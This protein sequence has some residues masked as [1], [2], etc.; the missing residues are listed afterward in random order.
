MQKYAKGGKV[1]KFRRGGTPAPGSK[2]VLGKIPGSRDYLQISNPLSRM[3][4]GPQVINVPKQIN[5][6]RNRLSAVNKGA[7]TNAFTGAPNYDYDPAY[8]P[9]YAPPEDL[10]YA[11]G[12]KVGKV[13]REYKAGKLHSG[14]KKGPLV[15]DRK[16]AVAIAMSEARRAGEKM[17][18]KKAKGGQMT[19]QERRALEKMR[20]AEKY[21]PGLSLDMPGKRVKKK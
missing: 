12:G 7:R 9:A 8:D 21:A 6:Q 17:P 16:Q 15:K 2:A 5:D 14:S 19:P 18:M 20:H 10:E 13:M 11:R 4:I 3:G 1:Q